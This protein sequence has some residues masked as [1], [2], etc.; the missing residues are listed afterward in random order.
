MH[1]QYAALRVASVRSQSRFWSISFLIGISAYQRHCQGISFASDMEHAH[2]LPCRSLPKSFAVEDMRVLFDALDCLENL[3][4][5]VEK[6][7]IDSQ[8]PVRSLVSFFPFFLGRWSSSSFVH[9]SSSLTE[10]R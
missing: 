9:S 8:S 5:N 1:D 4:I 10:A 2:C 3:D 7:G 6:W